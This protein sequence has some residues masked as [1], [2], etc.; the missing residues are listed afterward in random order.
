MRPPKGPYR[1][2]YGGQVDR[3]RKVFFRFDGKTYIGHPGDTLASA[4][5][6][7]GV[8]TVARSF[9]FHRP[10]GLFSCGPEEPSA[11]VEAG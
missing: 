3:T 4:L 8:H 6:A 9:K 10:R 1:L 5:L 11:L 7:N 2:P